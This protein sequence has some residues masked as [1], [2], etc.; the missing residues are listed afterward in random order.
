MDA[1]GGGGSLGES[2]GQRS[3]SRLGLGGAR[4]RASFHVSPRLGAG[5]PPALLLLPWNKT[6]ASSGRGS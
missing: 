5:L 4:A 3:L 6:S 2:A 1:F